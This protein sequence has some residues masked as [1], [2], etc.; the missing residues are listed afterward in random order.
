MCRCLYFTLGELLP[1]ILSQR[2]IAKPAS[3]SK[4]RTG[5]GAYDTLLVYPYFFQPFDGGS[6]RK[7]QELG[8]AL[9]FLAHQPDDVHRTVEHIR[10]RNQE[11][12]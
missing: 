6:P 10:Q 2:H 5:T 9:Q 1:K 11:N 8:P 7:V 3:I 4:Q 12:P